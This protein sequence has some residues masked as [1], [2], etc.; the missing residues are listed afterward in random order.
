M[1][2]KK[3]KSDA[4]TQDFY[5]P[6]DWEA[7]HYEFCEQSGY[8]EINGNAKTTE[9][10]RHFSLL[11]PPPN[12]T[13]VLHIGHALTFTL[14]DIMA[15]YKRMDGYR[16]L[17]QPGLD[18]A[19]I[20]TQNVVEKQLLAQGLSKEELGRE[21]FIKRVWEWK[22]ESGGAIL[23][24]MRR[25]LISPAFS[26]LRFTMDKGLAYAVRR[27]FCDLYEAG[28]IEQAPRMINWC[29]HDGALSDIEVVHESSKSKLYHLRYFF[30]NDASKY[31][32]VA[33]TRP[34]TFFGDSA[35]MV[36]PD[37]LRYKELIGSEL[38][39][40]LI[41]R[42]IKIIA[43]SVVDPDFGSGAVKVTPAHDL[44]DYEVGLRHKLDFHVIFDEKGILNS[45]CAEFAGLERLEAREKVLAKLLE[46]GQ[47]ERIEDYENQVGHC[48]RCKNIT[49]PYISTQWF[50][51][52]DIAR[53]VAK[54]VA[55]GQS[56]FFPARE[57]NNF[58]AW[59]RE[60]R[61]W[62]ISRQLWWGH[63][64]PVFYCDIC[65]S[66]RASMSDENYCCST[67]MRQD[68]DV[69][70]TWFSSGLFATSTLGMHN[71]D[72]GK[73][74]LWS[75][76]DLKD[77]YPHSLLITGFDIL[78]F[79]VCRMFFQNYQQLG[80]LPF[81]EVY[82]H[83]LV[84]DKNGQKMSKSLGNTIDPLEAI[85]VYG[86]DAL[87]LAL[88]LGAV[89]GR[90]IRFSDERLVLARNF[91]NKLFNAAKFLLLNESSFKDISEFK[92]KRPLGLFMLSALKNCVREVRKSLDE[93]RFNDAAM[94]LYKFFWDEFCDWGLELAKVDK[95]AIPELGAVFKE[96]L[97]VLSPFMPAFADFLYLKLSG[98][99]LKEHGSLMITRLLELKDDVCANSACS[100]NV[101]SF[102]LVQ[103]AIVSL[104]RAKINLELLGTL[105]EAILISADF[106]ESLLHFV[107]KLA[108][109]SSI[110]LYKELPDELK[111]QRF[112][113]DISQNLSVLIRLE[114]LDLSAIIKRLKARLEKLDKEIS[115]LNAMLQ[116]PK[117][118]EKAPADLVQ[119]NKENL[120]ALLEQKR[121]V[122]GELKN[123]E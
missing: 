1:Q 22:E 93:Y 81:R 101:L 51:K 33:T 113:K 112:A 38:V 72:W 79:W 37:D 5:V 14:Q 95:E 100:K 30:A 47:I 117:F 69:L 103:E 58:N 82:L 4:M 24:Q 16:V 13:G 9:P 63:Q 12:V 67:L 11:M 73:A 23:N 70:D 7:L 45:L 56:K 49:E 78:F 86:A 41:G 62:C 44:N 74:E 42:K 55:K 2:A 107:E 99:E 80:Q 6:K 39:L 61:P 21:E 92:L 123:Y 98:R 105:E 76:N 108:K 114:G 118:L 29:T 8:F 110:R 19:G 46:N 27:A 116:S 54:A 122:E 52:T 71:E 31:V 85:D 106:D 59:L 109:T 60:L 17:Y 50:V 89:Q 96:G 26:R 65:N 28:L 91:T 32:V 64:I 40:P 121:A 120:A 87:R 43:D 102:K 115:K 104:R 25:L 20:A 36:H 3:Q 53:G 75:E 88:A 83:A 10:N 68:P 94:A 77:F 18:H 66:Q 34:E 57:I 97:R 111:A 90:D 48:Y 15:R 84:K 119:S 35:V